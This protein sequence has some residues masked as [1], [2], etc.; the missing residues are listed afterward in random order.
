MRGPR[1]T[2]QWWGGGGGGVCVRACVG[3]VGAGYAQS[4]DVFVVLAYS[5]IHFEGFVPLPSK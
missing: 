4:F 5:V 2:R 3:E 1:R